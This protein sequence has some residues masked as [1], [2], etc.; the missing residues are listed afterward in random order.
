M[1]KPKQRRKFWLCHSKDLHTDIQKKG[2]RK[3]GRKERKKVGIIRAISHLR[4]REHEVGGR[5][6]AGREQIAGSEAGPS[7]T[8]QKPGP[9]D[10]PPAAR[11]HLLK[12]GQS[13]RTVLPAVDQVFLHRNLWQT[14]HTHT[15]H[16]AG[17]A[18]VSLC[19]WAMSAQKARALKGV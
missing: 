15:K 6:E 10:P 7:Y 8:R 11:P 14:R 1:H 2:E 12:H 16:N 3:I 9:S 18:L 13:L 5:T 17:R 4:T 19:Y